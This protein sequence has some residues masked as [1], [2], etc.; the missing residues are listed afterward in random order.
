M[1]Q[2][3]VKGLGLRGKV[4]SL[5]TNVSFMTVEV[6]HAELQA[7]AG[8]AIGGT[9]KAKIDAA[10]ASG[11]PFRVRIDHGIHAA[12]W[13]KTAI[14]T[15]HVIN[16]Q[17]GQSGDTIKFWLP[18]AL[19]IYE[20]LMIK[21][22]A[23]YPDGTLACIFEAFLMTI[24]AEPFIKGIRSGSNP[25]QAQANCT[26]LWNAGYRFDDISKP[27]DEVRAQERVLTIIS[28][29][30]TDTR[31]AMA[32]STMEHITSAT[33]AS[34][35]EAYTKARML[36]WRAALPSH[37]LQNNSLRDSQIANA[38]R[39]YRPSGQLFQ[40]MIA[41]GKPLSFQTGA[42]VGVTPGFTDLKKTG[43]FAAD[44]GAHA[45]EAP[46]GA[47]S[48]SWGGMTTTQAG[49]V[50]TE[51][52]ANDSGSPPAA[53]K[54]RVVSVN[55]G[56]KPGQNVA[57]DVVIESDDAS[58]IPAD[59]S[60]STGVTLSVHTGTGAL[61]GMVSGSIASGSSRLTLS[62]SYDTVESGVVLRATRTSGD[63]L[64][65]GDS[66]PFDVD[67]VAD[68]PP[69]PDPDPPPVAAAV[70]T[71]LL[72]SVNGV[73]PVHVS[74]SFFALVH[75]ADDSGIYR[76]VLVDT[77]I[78]LTLAAGSGA[79][80]GT[81]TG[82]IPA[83]RHVLT[84]SG[85]LYDT[86]ESGVALLADATVG[87]DL[88]S[89]TSAPFDVTAAASP[90]PS[91]EPWHVS[92]HELDGTE[93]IAELPLRDWSFM[94]EL[95]GPGSFEAEINMAGPWQVLRS[96][97]EPGQKEYRCFEGDVLRAAGRIWAA[98]VDPG[99]DTRK[100]KLVGNGHWSVIQ[101]R[102]VDWEVRY[103]PDPEDPPNP[104]TAYGYDQ[105][106][107]V[108]DLIDRSQSE[109]GGDIG[110]T[111]GIHEGDPITRRRWYCV[112]DGVKVSDV[113]EEFEAL[114]E[115]IDYAI[116]P[117]LTDDSLKQFVTWQ[118]KRGTDLSGS[119]V[120]NPED[121][122]D[123][124]NY[125]IDAGNLITR[126]HSRG[127]GDCEP[128]TADITDDLALAG[129]GLLEDFDSVSSEDQADVTEDAQEMLASRRDA[130][131]AFDVYYWLPNGPAIGDFDIGD[132]VRFI[133]DR[134]GWGMDEVLRVNEV[135]V[136]IQMPQTPFVR[137]NLGPY[138]DELAS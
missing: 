138:S 77:D 52:K 112:E 26:T 1:T 47:Y 91:T 59:V 19:D 135:E 122:L 102:G 97:V 120:F 95:N 55:G 41:V 42:K 108:F 116:T 44:M 46:G 54:L 74:E 12:P 124:L 119:I 106:E 79:L 11:I 137:V 27:G 82:T 132:L 16:P 131:G 39:P 90:S 73:A 22:E 121:Y 93:T 130:L 127:E 107:I 30:F 83:G 81:L 109:P 111:D 76:D 100:V 80:S 98:R 71:K 18:G 84:I 9:G 113:A 36:A 92:I 70:A 34:A 94:H 15:V 49:I 32:Y 24:F 33:S 13:A 64:S 66:D 57:F 48:S 56:V 8:A 86:A 62:V 63:S 69:P 126:A 28:G 104:S 123:T 72:I 43:D 29:L 89:V 67:T 40:D 75:S 87:D 38:S 128:P 4:N 125:E 96:D 68:P 85:I 60:A 31:I 99:Q 14:G 110:I 105:S 78:V 21:V 58:D 133:D 35:D 114:S 2:A 23:A 101:R 50:D 20:D 3:L 61:S 45:M 25:S 51:L 17:S 53:T 134:D 136:T 37:I 5:P 117:T 6:T 103:E 129:Y 10:I 7:S 88:A 115:G 118:P 65:L